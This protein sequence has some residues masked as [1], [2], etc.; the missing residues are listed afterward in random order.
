MSQM[1]SGPQAPYR[2]HP[3]DE[4]RGRPYY[5]EPSYGG[6]ISPALLL[7][8]LAVV[9]LGFLAWHYLGPDL[10]RYLKIREM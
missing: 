4:W 6:G 8:G 2:P 9:G 5:P 3:A 7:G 1:A 10:V